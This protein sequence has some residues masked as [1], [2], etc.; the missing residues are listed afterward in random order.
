MKKILFAFLLFLFAFP[1]IAQEGGPGRGGR[2]YLKKIGQL[3][4]AKL[5]EALNLDENT[6]IKFFARRNENQE[7]IKNLFDEREKILSEMENNFKANNKNS[8]DYYKKSI[9]KLQKIDQKIFEE[10]YAFI[11]SLRE[12]FSEEQIARY[13]AFEYSFRKEI[14][15]SLIRH[16]M[17]E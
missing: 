3:E 11:N 4:K 6:A 9:D 13:L 7:K 5:I 12:I 8:E 16:R 2:A 10:K 15:E 1:L 14:R 17:R